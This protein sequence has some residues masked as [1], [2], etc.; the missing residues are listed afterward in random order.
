MIKEQENQMK[1][2]AIYIRCAKDAPYLDWEAQL[3]Q[4]VEK[5]EDLLLVNCFVDVGCSGYNIN[6][7]ALHKLIAAVE[8]GSV[9]AIVVK[10]FASLSRNPED[11]RKLLEI[12]ERTKTTIYDLQGDNI[13]QIP[14]RPLDKICS[15]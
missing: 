2:A 7:P 12:F 15:F 4:A 14:I 5:Q 1:R 3:K 13:Q 8:V 9:D 10:Q 6:R 11:I